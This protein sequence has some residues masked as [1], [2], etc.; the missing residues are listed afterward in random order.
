MSGWYIYQNTKNKRYGFVSEEYSYNNYKFWQHRIRLFYT[1]FY[2][3]AEEI[4]E[5]MNENSFKIIK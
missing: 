2:E 4:Q 1:E 3:I 5:K